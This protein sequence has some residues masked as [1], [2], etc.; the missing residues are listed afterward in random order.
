[1]GGT[2]FTL[3]RFFSRGSSLLLSAVRLIAQLIDELLHLVVLAFNITFFLPPNLLIEL[4]LSMGFGQ[5]AA[6]AISACEPV[7]RLFERRCRFNSVA[8]SGDRFRQILLLG[9]DDSQLQ[10]R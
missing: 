6:L 7:I 9:I 10:I 2:G 3:L 5:V 4:Q 1:M 8:I